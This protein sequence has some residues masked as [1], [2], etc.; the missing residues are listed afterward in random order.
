MRI[1]ISLLGMRWMNGSMSEEGNHLGG[2]PSA[3]SAPTSAARGR[4]RIEE[5]A[6]PSLNTPEILGFVPEQ[7]LCWDPSALFM[8]LS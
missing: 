7:P 3:F 2:F 5:K 6:A 4:S 1:E 8:S